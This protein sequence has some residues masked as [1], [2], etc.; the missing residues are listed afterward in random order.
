MSSRVIGLGTAA[1]DIVLQCN[2]LPRADGF[3]FV[4]NELLTPGG[5]CANVLAALVGLGVST[6]LIAKIGGDAYGQAFYDDLKK[7]GIDADYVKVVPG[8][9]TLHTFITVAPDGSRSIFANLGNTLLS[10]SEDEVV[11]E[12][13]D[14]A[15]VF[16]TDMFPGKPALK[17]AR[18]CQ[19]R[20]IPVIFNLQCPPS[21]MCLCGVP[22]REIAQ[23]IS[24]SS[25]V[26]GSAD[27][28]TELTGNNDTRRAILEIYRW[29]Q[30][31]LGVVCTLGAQ[32][33][34]WFYDRETYA[35]ESYPVETVDTTGAGDAFVA[36][37]IS[38]HFYKG[39]LPLES[40]RFASACAAMKCMQAGPR[41]K[42]VEAQ[43]WEFMKRFQTP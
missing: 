18:I 4:H 1:M 32:G 37:L 12:M 22:R 7:C 14:E 40:M 9:V 38:A 23:M 13:L 5:S 42:V 11:P 16:Y 6:S 35:V 10:L 17:L 27:A 25:L 30:P 15:R 31:R 2:A 28:F 39:L 21:F 8:G 34:V 3:A 26:V 41:L 43:V 33:A 29:G 24:V 19:D 20:N 36:G